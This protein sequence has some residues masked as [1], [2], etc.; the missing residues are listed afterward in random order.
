[1]S[2]GRPEGALIGP[3][4]AGP[5]GPHG[6]PHGRPRRHPGARPPPRGARPVAWRAGMPGS[7]TRRDRVWVTPQ[8]GLC[9][10]ALAAPLARRRRPPRGVRLLGAGRLAGGAGV[11][12]A[13]YRALGGSHS[14]WSTPVAG[15]RLVTTGIYRWVRHPI[16]GGWCLGALGA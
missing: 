8:A 1:R 4:A 7:V 14:P 2:R 3:G 9:L 10:A 11:A 16:Y 15:G 5:V 13:G 6:G 12:L